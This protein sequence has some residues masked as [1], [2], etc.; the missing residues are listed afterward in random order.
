MSEK[1]WA[2]FTLLLAVLTLGSARWAFSSGAVPSWQP[3]GPSLPSPQRPEAPG[4]SRE[5]AAPG[6]ISESELRVPGSDFTAEPKATFSLELRDL[7]SPYGL[8]SAFVMPGEELELQVPGEDG[9]GR[10]FAARAADGELVRRGEAAWAWR[11]PGKPGLYSLAVTDT[12][13][14]ETIRLNAFVFRPYQGLELLNGYRIGHYQQVPLRGDPVYNPPRGFIEVTPELMDAPL[15]PH[16]RLHQFLCKQS[17]G[18]PK[19]LVLR[20]HLLLKLEEILERVREEGIEAETFQVMSGY[21]TPWYNAAIGNRTRY[22]RHGYGDA[23]DIFVDEDGDG[24]MDDLTG[25]GRV[26]RLDA[27]HLYELV[28]GMSYE[29]HS[30]ELVGGLGLYGPAPHRGPF[31]HVDVRG[32][33]ARW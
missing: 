31:V 22:S 26:D 29:E 14:G 5:P 30:P 9:A 20:E 27:E 18:F 11:A 25:D 33:R 4:E 6:T 23:A 13:S 8:M 15:S 7:R 28:E 32:F 12:G 10:R 17:S 24:R 16:F 21:R 2:V 3:E 19:Y 1:P